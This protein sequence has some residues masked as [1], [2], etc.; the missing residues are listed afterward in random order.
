[1][2]TLSADSKWREPV[3]ETSGK[4]IPMYADI[5]DK[6]AQ[7]LADNII[8]S[9]LEQMEK[10]EPAELQPIQTPETLAE[11][12]ASAIVEVALKD[13]CLPQYPPSDVEKNDCEE[14]ENGPPASGEEEDLLER[15]MISLR[16]LQ[17]HRNSQSNH[18]PLYQ[19]GLPAVGSLDYPDAPPTTPLIPELERSRNSF[20]RKLK[21]GLAKVF[22]P[23][24]PPPTPK[25][26]EDNSGG[27]ISDPQVELMEHLMHSL[28][29]ND[30]ARDG[31][32]AH[33]AGV[34]A[35]AEVLSCDVLSWVLSVKNKQQGS[36]ESDLHQLAHQLAETIIT[37][38]LDKAKCDLLSD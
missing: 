21:G 9:S 29:T 11:E 26:K 23:S 6:F 35:F 16:E 18:P 36:D 30:L 7:N 33:G 5:L 27:V 31:L 24:P 17:T 34:E 13:V 12:L 22:L 37:S 28:S 38:S 15:E 14:A 3:P 10:L 25:D 2:Q 19:S 32:Q 8:L 1:M 20:A 4:G